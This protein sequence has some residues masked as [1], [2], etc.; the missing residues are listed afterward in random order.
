MNQSNIS[1]KGDGHGSVEAFFRPISDTPRVELRVVM[2]P[3]VASVTH[4]TE[5]FPCTPEISETVD[6]LH[7]IM[8]LG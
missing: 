1:P 8:V 4:F 5:P 3:A 7:T 2:Y 6:G